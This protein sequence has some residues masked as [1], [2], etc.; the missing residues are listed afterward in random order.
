MGEI[1]TRRVG[2]VGASGG[3]V[4]DGGLVRCGAP[5]FLGGHSM[6]KRALVPFKR[7]LH[8]STFNYSI[9]VAIRG[10]FVAV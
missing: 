5:P 3:S 4:F 8:T 10:G 7:V 1:A 9:N 6:W 2:V